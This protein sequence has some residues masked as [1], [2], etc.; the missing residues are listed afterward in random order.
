LAVTPAP[1]ISVRDGTVLPSVRV[2]D[3]S[4]ADSTVTPS[5]TSTPRPRSVPSAASP[6]SGPSS[7]STLW[8]TSTSSQRTSRG[9]IRCQRDATVCSQR[10]SWATVSVPV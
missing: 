7:G 1:Q 10:W 3:R 9:R 6:S 4:V 5:R 2:T 8:A